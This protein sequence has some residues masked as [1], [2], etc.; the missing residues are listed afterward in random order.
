MKSRSFQPVQ[1]NMITI[2]AMLFSLFQMV[3][4]AKRDEVATAK[5]I[6]LIEEF[7]EEGQ[8]EDDGLPLRLA[9]ESRQIALFEVYIV[10][11]LLIAILANVVANYI[12]RGRHYENSAR[13]RE[14]EAEMRAMRG[15]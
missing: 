10:G 13:I 5:A 7:V 2:V 3:A 12:G 4:V 9:A 8:I 6:Q 14:L 11:T 1:F 15:S